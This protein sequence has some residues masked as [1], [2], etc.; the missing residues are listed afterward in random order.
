MK[1]SYKAYSAIFIMF[2]FLP[3]LSLLSCNTSN[4]DTPEASDSVE[5]LQSN[6]A[7]N[8]EDLKEDVDIL[9]YSDFE[10]FV[11]G[12][13]DFSFS[14]YHEAKAINGEKNMFISPYSISCA[15]AMAWAG[16]R[17]DTEAQMAEA[18]NFS[19][20]QAD[21]HTFFNDLHETLN[22]KGADNPEGFRLYVS[23]AL[24][25]QEGFHFE[26]DYLD[27]ISEKYGSGVINFLDFISEPEPSR[28]IINKWV[29]EQ[30]EKRIKDLLPQGSVTSNS[31][32]VITN[33]IY[34][35]A[36]WLNKFKSGKTQRQDFYL[37]DGSIETVDMMHQ[38]NVFPYTEGSDYQA[39]ELLYKDEKTS[40]IVILPEDGEFNTVDHS[41]NATRVRQMVREM[42]DHK[43]SLSLPKFS[44]GYTMNGLAGIL[45]NMGMIDA[46][47]PATSDFSG[48]TGNKDLT[49]S[50]IAHKAFVRVDEEGTE[51][52]AATGTL[53]GAT[54]VPEVD[55]AM[56]IDRP[57]I[58]VILDKETGS[59]LFIGSV[60]DPTLS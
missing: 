34:F 33:T 15:L 11:M 38:L 14:L 25:G 39:V 1:K 36:D 19:F 45:T 55:T 48:I 60:V 22:T 4:S 16:A 20:S 46:F 29:E 49:I 23:N 10:K 42:S 28:I 27:I 24:W 59:I 44:F 40:M 47:F 41:L 6:D 31:R 57:F 51:A 2:L 26:Q 50:K 35:L 3:A 37:V 53:M 30:T 58:F 12:N 18:L 54:S 32:L 56:K 21:I 5:P 17:G 9:E 7:Q 13:N 43:V 52:A 8:F